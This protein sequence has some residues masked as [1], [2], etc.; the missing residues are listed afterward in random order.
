M[1]FFSKIGPEVQATLQCGNWKIK[2][3][4]TKNI[5]NVTLVKR[6]RRFI[7]LRDITKLSYVVSD[8]NTLWYRNADRFSA[9]HVRGRCLMFIKIISLSRMTV[10]SLNAE[11][12]IV[13]HVIFSLPTILFQVILP[14]VHFPHTVSRICLVNHITWCTL[15]NALFVGWYAKGKPKESWEKEWTD[16]DPQLIL[17]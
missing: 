10:L 1:F 9:S 14:N 6:C 16:T 2:K 8:D 4:K 17:G 13:R 3:L 11:P 15:S 12:K 5:P 7:V